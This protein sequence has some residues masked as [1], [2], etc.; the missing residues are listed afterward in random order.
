MSLYSY[1]WLYCTYRIWHGKLSVNCTANNHEWIL[2]RNFRGGSRRNL[3]IVIHNDICEIVMLE[4]NFFPKKLLAYRQARQALATL[5]W[6]QVSPWY[7]S[8]IPHGDACT[9]INCSD[10]LPPSLDGERRS[11]LC[12]EQKQKRLGREASPLLALGPAL[13]NKLHAWWLERPY[14]WV[15]LFSNK[16]LKSYICLINNVDVRYSLKPDNSRHLLVFQ[17][18]D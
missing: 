10:P 8:C 11:F 12:R 13:W 18:M 5:L 2:S 15:Y 6:L 16:R 4:K 7:R 1:Y 9:E 17:L 3:I 14:S